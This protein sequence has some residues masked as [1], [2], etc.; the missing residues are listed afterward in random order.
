MIQGQTKL[1]GTIVV[2]FLF[3]ALGAGGVPVQQARAKPVPVE[4]VQVKKKDLPVTVQRMG[5]LKASA[6][7][8]LKPRVSG[9]IEKVHFQSG[10]KVKKGQLLF[11][12]D[13]KDYQLKLNEAKA[14]L[15][16]VKEQLSETTSQIHRLE[17]LRNKNYISKQKLMDKKS[18]ARV[19]ERKVQAHKA[20]VKIARNQLGYCKVKAPISAVAGMVDFKEGNLASSDMRKP[21][22]KLYAIT[23]MYADFKV[24]AKYITEIAQKMD[25]SSLPLKVIVPGKDGKSSYQG[26]TLF[27]S[28]EVYKQSATVNIRGKLENPGGELKSGQFVWV[29]LKIKEIKDAVVVPDKAVQVNADGPYVYVVGSGKKASM[30]KIQTGELHNGQRVV[31]QGLKPG[32]RVVSSGALNL[33]SGQP[34]KIINKATKNNKTKQ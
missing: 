17:N 3:W 2:F 16:A 10:Q 27:M 5:E 28:P 19:F 6:V 32:E 30:R 4:T 7:V 14:Q 29:R 20:E 15:A 33:K 18:Q 26:K 9:R 23:P 13:P 8:Q 1:F 34:V 11:S 24:P 22:V 25:N 12:L 21:L 31:K